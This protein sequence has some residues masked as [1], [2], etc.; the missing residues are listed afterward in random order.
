MIMEERK[1]KIM[2]GGGVMSGIPSD[3]LF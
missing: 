1:F 2:K 3:F